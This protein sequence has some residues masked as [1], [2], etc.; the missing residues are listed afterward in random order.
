MV[1]LPCDN[2]MSRWVLRDKLTCAAHGK[3]AVMG[4][5]VKQFFFF[6]K[7][8]KVK[9]SGYLFYN[10]LTLNINHFIL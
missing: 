6:L 9:G 4:Q 7:K 8:K 2:R 5:R 3:I 1:A 10:Y